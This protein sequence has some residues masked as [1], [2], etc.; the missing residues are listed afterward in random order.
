MSDLTFTRGT[1]EER[2]RGRPRDG[3]DEGIALLPPGLTRTILQDGTARLG[4][5]IVVFFVGFALAAPLLAPHDPIAISEV[6]LAPPS[7]GH[8]LGTDGLGRDLLSRLMFGARLSLGTAFLAAVLVTTLGVVLGTVAGFYRGAA[9]TVIM[10]VV[11]VIL[12]FPGL[13]LALAIAGLFNPGILTVV[14]G[15]VTVWWVSYARIIRGLVASIR[16]R[17]FVTSARAL[18]AGNVRII[19]HH[20]LPHVLP[21]VIVLVTLEMG[22]LIL[23]ISALSFLGLGAQPPIPEWGA[24]LNDGRAYFF[25]DPRVILMPGVAI[26]LVVLGFNLLGD[27]IRDALDPKL[28]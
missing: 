18:G 14:L 12:A 17:E 7:W 15:L 10:G 8:P 27:G 2:E 22:S 21:P 13:V 11:D 23:A 24:M 9:E 19:C 1:A 3:E 16:E 28:K 5:A 6:S 26:S 4:L 25:S 20:I